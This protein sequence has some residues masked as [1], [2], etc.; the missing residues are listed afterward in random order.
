[1]NVRSVFAALAFVSLA[2]PLAA[3]ADAP[4]G[5]INTVFAI[6]QATQ[7]SVPDFDRRE[8]R[9][10]VEDILAGPASKDSSQVTRE[11]VRE[12]LARMPVE[13]VGA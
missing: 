1:M 13:R 6:D 10:Y 12:E 11:Q 4:S 9:T 7:A 8:H 3:H 2:A 5:D